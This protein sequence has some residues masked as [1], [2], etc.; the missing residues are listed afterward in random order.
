MCF[1]A[2]CGICRIC[3]AGVGA[4]DRK[5]WH[6]EITH[7]SEQAIQCGLIDYLPPEQGLAVVLERDGQTLKPVSPLRTQMALDP[8][9]IDYWLTWIC[10]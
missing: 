1:N 2:L 8:D 4:I 9:L 10:C 3:L 6:T 7:F 5:Q